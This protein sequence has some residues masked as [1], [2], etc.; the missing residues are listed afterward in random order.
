MMKN[1]FAIIKSLTLRIQK[2]HLY[3][4]TTPFEITNVPIFGQPIRPVRDA[5][6]SQMD[7]MLV[8]GIKPSTFQRFHVF[9]MEN[10]LGTQLGWGHVE[11]APATIS[12]GLRPFRWKPTNARKSRHFQS[13]L[14]M[15]WRF[16]TCTKR[17]CKT[18][19][20][21]CRSKSTKAGCRHRGLPS[22]SGLFSSCPCSLTQGESNG[23]LAVIFATIT[24]FWSGCNGQ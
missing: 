1:S 16:Y 9:A 20:Q 12:V 23:T 5:F 18:F 10:H 24:S 19:Q 4:I 21:L 17:W 3:N 7:S 15:T 2:A 11:L 13:F 14:P 22:A 6:T 8:H